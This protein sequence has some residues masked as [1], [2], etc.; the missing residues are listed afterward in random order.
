MIGF[1]GGSGALRNLPHSIGV[2]V[3]DMHT[4]ITTDADKVRANSRISRPT[5]P[6]MNIRGVNTA[7]R[8]IEI[9]RMVKPISP[10]PLR[11]AWNGF[12]PCSIRR[13]MASTMTMASSPT[14]SAAI[15]R[16]R[17]VGFAAG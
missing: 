14:N 6:L 9:D 11:A 12:S 7:I 10:E 13:Q 2:K 16:A 4:E 3:S 15:E 8:E 1:L 17:G 5:T